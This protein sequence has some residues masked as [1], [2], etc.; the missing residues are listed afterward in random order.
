M[1]IKIN[2]FTLIP[3]PANLSRFDL[4]KTVTR[5][6]KNTEEIYEAEQEEGYGMQ[7]ETIIQKIIMSNLTDK[8]ETCDLKTFIAEYKKEKDIILQ[9]TGQIK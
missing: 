9:L 4:T 5:K 1:N 8:K 2:Q 3:C 7:L 6:K